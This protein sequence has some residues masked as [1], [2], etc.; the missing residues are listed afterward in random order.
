MHPALAARAAEDER[1][2]GEVTLQT[3]YPILRYVDARAAITWL[4]ETFGFALVFS[5]PESGDHVRHA[6]LSLGGNIIMLGSVREGESL[7]SPR[8]IGASTQ[9]L[10]VHVDDLEAHYQ[11]TLLAGA[12]VLAPPANTAFGSREYHVVDPEG[13]SWSFGTYRPGPL[14]G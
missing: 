13:H 5:V 8:S 7:G 4:C 3:I 11:R 12:P 1:Q 9:A 14:S 2:A 6:Q 10:Y